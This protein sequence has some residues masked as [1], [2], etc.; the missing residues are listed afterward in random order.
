MGR[1][2]YRINQLFQLGGDLV[3]WQNKIDISCIDRGLRHA[4]IPRCGSILSDDLA[5]F[6]FDNLDPEGS[7]TVSTSEDDCN[8]ILLINRSYRCK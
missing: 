3:Q 7:V 2:K 4:E 6:L 5:A 8:G 1:P